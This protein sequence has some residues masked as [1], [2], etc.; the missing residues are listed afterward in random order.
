MM[1]RPPRCHRCRRE[2]SLIGIRR[3]PIQIGHTPQFYEGVICQ[4]CMKVECT[5]C[6]GVPLDA[7]CSSCSGPVS[8]AYEHLIP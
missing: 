3:A 2:L 8:P 7:A 5:A 4:E 1:S 6:K